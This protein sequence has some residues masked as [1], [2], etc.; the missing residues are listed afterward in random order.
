MTSDPGKH[1]FLIAELENGSVGRLRYPERPGVP[2][3]QL[4]APKLASTD[5]VQIGDK[6]WK[7]GDLVE[8]LAQF[9]PADGNGG[10][11]R[12]LD[13][14]GQLVLGQY[15]ADQLFSELNSERRYELNTADSVRLVIK[16]RDSFFLSLP[17]TLLVW[18]RG[19]AV[20]GNWTIAVSAQPDFE[21][22]TVRFSQTHQFLV[23][24]PDPLRDRPTDA[25]EHVADLVKRLSDGDSGFEEGKLLRVVRTVTELRDY[26]A[27]RVPDAVYFY[28]H[29]LKTITGA[30]RLLFEG[31]EGKGEA[32]DVVQFANLLSPDGQRPNLV[33]VNCCHGDDGGPTGIG[34]QLGRRFDAVLT[35]RARV[36]QSPARKQAVQFWFDVL[37]MARNP[38]TS[39]RNLYRSSGTDWGNFQQPHW[40][41]VSLYVGYGSWEQLA[42]RGIDPNWENL[43]DR[44]KNIGVVLNAVTMMLDHSRLRGTAFVLVGDDQSGLNHFHQ[45]LETELPLRLLNRSRQT[46]IPLAWPDQFPQGEDTVALFRAM[47]LKALEIASLVELPGRLQRKAGVSGRV[48]FYFRHVPLHSAQQLPP[49]YLKSYLEFWER[50]VLGCLDSNQRGILAVS[51]EVPVQEVISLTNEIVGEHRLERGFN[52]PTTRVGCHV[53]DPLDLVPEDDLARFCGHN[54]FGFP[55]DQRFDEVITAIMEFT[56]GHYI[57]ILAVLKQLLR[58]GVPLDWNEWINKLRSRPTDSR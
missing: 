15:F 35:H 30:L 58:E 23:I 41:S 2:P 38:E 6:N 21:Q 40:C 55:Q 19:F 25:K 44:T 47:Y 32:I 29:G 4:N 56:G 13:D 53:L 17:W 48:V 57:Q 26:M 43:M 3:V 27:V 12:P 16:T 9:D 28:G 7:L 36:F 22:K 1:L 10:D 31:N 51:Y 24:A 42:A 18:E 5:T 46:S 11:L 52:T 20:N 33:Y 8:M 37:R 54:D 49:A 50:E 45:R 39:V 14:R 34:W